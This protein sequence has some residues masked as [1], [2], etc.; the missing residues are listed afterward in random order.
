[1][2]NRPTSDQQDETLKAL[3][4]DYTAP[5]E[6]NGFTTAVMA[7]LQTNAQTFNAAD[8]APAP[9]STLRSWVIALTLGLIGGM[10][11]VRLGINLP[12][13]SGS[14]DVQN[15]FT[16]SWAVYAICGFVLAGL[17]LFIEAEA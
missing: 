9:R 8:F 10:L 14:T 6:D 3:L 4:A 11:W 12:D 17:M 5:T 15:F 7:R 2:N 16:H 1:M 13:L